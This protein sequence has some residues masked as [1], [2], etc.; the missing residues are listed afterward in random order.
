MLRRFLI[1]RC[2]VCYDDAFAV[3]STRVVIVDVLAGKCLPVIPQNSTVW[4]VRHSP[5]THTVFF[6]TN[7]GELGLLQ[8]FDSVKSLEHAKDLP[9]RRL[10][11]SSIAL[12]STDKGAF[13]LKGDYCQSVENTSLIFQEPALVRHRLADVNS[14]SHKHLLAPHPEKMSKEDFT[15]YPLVGIT[16]LSHNSN[17]GRLGLIFSGGPSGIGSII[18]LEYLNCHQ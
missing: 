17:P 8:L 14:L 1:G 10:L 12:D 15:S 11:V 6:A 16:T 18:D 5:W 13:R 2:L 7:A 3:S 4:A 9:Q